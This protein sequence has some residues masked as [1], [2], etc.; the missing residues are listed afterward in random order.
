MAWF[1]FGFVCVVWP[2]FAVAHQFALSLIV[3]YICDVHHNK[4][5]VFSS[6]AESHHW[7]FAVTFEPKRWYLHIKNAQSVSLQ[8]HEMHW[9][10]LRNC[11]VFSSAV[12]FSFRF[13]FVDFQCNQTKWQDE[14]S[15]APKINRNHRVTRGKNQS[16]SFFR[17]SRETLFPL[18][19]FC[20]HRVCVWLSIIFF[21]F[22]LPFI[23]ILS[24][25]T[26]N[27]AKPNSNRIE[28][29]DRGEDARRESRSPYSSK[30]WRRFNIRVCVLL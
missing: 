24:E 22:R 5:S 7:K 26:A 15:Y 10:K 28:L 17:L 3:P 11:A 19:H 9:Y 4:S 14:L 12:W 8:L 18:C 27:K 29:S 1:L 25:K 23:H 30:T 2:N 16:R 20:V 21:P 6:F 13:G